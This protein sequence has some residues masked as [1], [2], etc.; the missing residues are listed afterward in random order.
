[1]IGTTVSHYKIL[2]KLGG[3]GMGVVYKAQDTRL[4]RAVALKF[5]PPDLTRDSEARERFIHEAKAASALQHPNICTIHDVDETADNRLFI[6]MDCY[7]GESLKQILESGPL[8]IDKAIDIATQISQGLAKAHE[9]GIVHRDIKPANIMIGKDGI[10]RIVD[11][12]LAKL[13]GQT[14]LTKSGSMVGTAAYMSPEQARGEKVDYRT[15]IWSLG[16]VFYEMLTGLQPFASEYE[17]AM[18]Y[19][20]MSGEPNP[21]EEL[22]PEVPGNIIGIVQR[23]LEKVKEKRFQT[24][25]EMA[26]ALRG[27]GKPQKKRMSRR[28][29]RMLAFLTGTAVVILIA[30]GLMI[31]LPHGSP[32]MTSLAVLPFVNV[33]K[34]PKIEY[35]CDGLAEALTDQFHLMPNL[36]VTAFTSALCFKG[37]DILPSEIARQLGV[38]TLLVTRLQE[39]GDN[40]TLNAE[41]VNANENTLLWSRQFNESVGQRNT[42]PQSI[43][44]SLVRD[45]RFAPA[46]ASSDN[47]ARTGTNSEAYD[48]YLRGRYHYHK[49]TTKD[50]EIAAEY[51]R[52]AIS[53]D[54]TFALA[55]C[56]L[57]EALMLLADRTI[58]M[59]QI[60]DSILQEAKKAVALDN[61]LPAAHAV[62]GLALYYCRWEYKAAEQELLHA[63]ALDPSYAEAYHYYGHVLSERG[64]V[65]KGIEMMRQAV[66]FDPVSPTAQRCLAASYKDARRWD[67]AKHATERLVYK[68]ASFIGF[69]EL[70]LA[71]IFRNQGLLDS[72]RFCLHRYRQR[73]DAD[74]FEYHS[75]FAEIEAAAGNRPLVQE[76]IAEVEKLARSMFIDPVLLACVYASAGMKEKAFAKLEEAFRIFCGSLTLLTVWPEFDS[77]RTDPRFDKMV[78]RSG[79]LLE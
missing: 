7:E 18:M 59:I 26:E 49:I 36:K 9:S 47:V 28:K 48:L 38:G 75:R 50:F 65:I 20:I 41:L 23:A 25:S 66:E 30:M 77:L 67:E 58:P 42:I 74:P 4:D 17:Q 22:R 39:Q 73:A 8:P 62:L 56:G 76:H 3:G 10:A 51:H 43:F 33:A 46:R 63:L 19:A 21:I 32:E 55:H 60:R 45:L 54:S 29:K 78:Q 57:S 12:G 70:S 13:S 16:V 37:K 40:L 71:D 61:Q 34:D 14:M 79:G 53:L 44:L 5:L 72:A 69:V 6:V 68:D 35:L 31:L 52:K 15:D 2:E 27:E 11:F 24:A 64:S 1:M